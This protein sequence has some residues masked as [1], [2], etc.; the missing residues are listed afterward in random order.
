MSAT[1]LGHPFTDVKFFLSPAKI[2]AK[3]ITIG[4]ANFLNS[5]T[6]KFAGQC[7]RCVGSIES[8]I[9]KPDRTYFRNAENTAWDPDTGYRHLHDAD[10]DEAGG[11]FRDIL[12]ANI[13]DYLIADMNFPIGNIFHRSFTAGSGISDFRVSMTLFSGALTNDYS[14]IALQGGQ[15][16]FR[17]PSA[18]TIRG[19]T[20]TGAMMSIKYGIGVSD[21]VDLESLDPRY[22]LESCDVENIERNYNIISSDGT[23]WTLEP[24]SEPVAQPLHKGYKVNHIPGT[25]VTFSRFDTINNEVISKKTSDVPISGDVDVGNVFR[26]GIKTNTTLSRFYH[27]SGFRV[28]G[29][30]PNYY[31]PPAPLV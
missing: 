20:E 3:T 16:T 5:M 26:L 13:S 15:L 25:E 12:L 23:S 29:K 27:M 11:L 18:F 19:S 7:V 24:T 30:M 2:N 28:V 22:G 14:Q 8:G 10:E 6:T 4:D 17:Y 9:F 21:V 31:W 1:E